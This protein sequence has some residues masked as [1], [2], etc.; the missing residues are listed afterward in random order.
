MGQRLNKPKEKQTHN[1]I[2][3]LFIIITT[4]KKRTYLTKK[5][6]KYEA[7]KKENWP[8]DAKATLPLIIFNTSWHEILKIQH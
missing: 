5:I 1:K 3:K 6:S 2:N 4:T 7:Q 8:K